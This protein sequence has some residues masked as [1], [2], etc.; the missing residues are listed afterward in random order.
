MQTI[1]SKCWKAVNRIGKTL[2]IS[3]NV[4]FFLSLV[5]Y[6]SKLVKCNHHHLF[7]SCK[8]RNILLKMAFVFFG[9]P[10]KPAKILKRTFAKL[11]WT[12]FSLSLSRSQSSLCP[13]APPARYPWSPHLPLHYPPDEEW[14]HHTD[15]HLHICLPGGGHAAGKQLQAIVCCFDA[16]GS[17]FL[18]ISWLNWPCLYVCMDGWMYVW[19][20]GNGHRKSREVLWQ[21]KSEV[22]NCLMSV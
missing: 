7:D 11:R 10:G 1:L 6:L 12:I 5:I 9:K 15:T 4:F 2:T 3:Q 8:K 13:G 18:F 22:H 19:M 21:K 20:D 17:I 14:P 16:Q